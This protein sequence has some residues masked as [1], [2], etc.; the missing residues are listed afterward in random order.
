VAG[1]S[2][3]NWLIPSDPVE[4]PVFLASYINNWLQFR[5]DSGFLPTAVGKPGVFTLYMTEGTKEPAT[6]DNCSAWDQV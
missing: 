4:I 2:T 1:R 3:I 5:N 6:K